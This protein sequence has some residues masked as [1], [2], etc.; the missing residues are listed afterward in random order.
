MRSLWD[1]VTSAVAHR[2]D[3]VST[4]GTPTSTAN[5][6]SPLRAAQDA[7]PRLEWTVEPRPA[8]DEVRRLLIVFNEIRMTHR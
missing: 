2:W 3:P 4:V 7:T 6:A 8:G 1:A 5:A